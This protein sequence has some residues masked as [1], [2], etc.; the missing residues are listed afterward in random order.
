MSGYQLSTSYTFSTTLPV[1]REIKKHQRLTEAAGL[2]IGGDDFGWRKLSGEK[3]GRNLTPLAQK[4]MQELAAYVWEANRLANRLIE[5]P[6]AFL[7]GEGVKPEVDDEEA[8]SWIDEFWKDPINRLDLNLEKHVRELAIF[9]EQ[10][11][12]VF[13]NEHTGRVRLG[14]IDPSRIDR[15]IVDPDNPAVVI[16]VKVEDRQYRVIYNAPEEELFGS[17]ALGLRAT[18]PDEAFYYRINDLSNGT[19]GRS[20]LLS[21]IDFVDA[22]EQLLFGEVERSVALRQVSWDVTITGGT[23]EDIA[24]RA[25]DIQPPE[26]LSVRVHNENE[27][28][29]MLTPSLNS[30]DASEASRLIRNHILGGSTVPEHWFGGGGDVNLATA[31]SMGEPTYKVFSQRQKLWKAI[32]EDVLTFV[33]RARVNALGR[34]DLALDVA[35][36]PRAVF[37]ELT[38][39]DTSKYAVA[40]QQIVVACVQAVNGGVMSDD[41]AVRLIAMMAD[42]LGIEIDP[43]EELDLARKDAARRAEMDVYHDP[44][45]ATDLAGLFNAALA[46]PEPE[47][48]PRDPA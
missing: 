33:I 3:T 28:W 43:A 21:A 23:P 13:V 32:L 5:L 16:G 47:P 19:R 10:L 4:R 14:K 20:D 39:R 9:G 44:T 40:L 18:M 37:P 35:Y 26:P 11:W 36:Q 8:Q 46:D 15:V 6:V 17:A 27:K 7:L 30:A 1:S 31:S 38:A 42:A 22:Y 2:S 25:R 34:A 45:P 29:Q 12:P 48:L 24:E 41:T